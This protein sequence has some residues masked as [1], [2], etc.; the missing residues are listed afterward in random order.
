MKKIIT[1]FAFIL[2]VGLVNAQTDSTKA[3]ASATNSGT[4]FDYYPDANVYYNDAAK[5]YWYQDSATNQWQSAAQLPTG[6]SI[7]NNSKKN[8]FYYN[9]GDVWKANADHVKMYGNNSKPKKPAKDSI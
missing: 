3:N 7:D 1:A 8:S 2:S 6:Y 9:G 5:T 4:K